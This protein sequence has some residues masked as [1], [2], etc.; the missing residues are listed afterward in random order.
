M[1][2]VGRALMSDPRLLMLDE[3]SLGLAPMVVTEIFAVLAK[4]NAFRGDGSGGGTGCKSLSG[5]RPMGLCF[6]KRTH[7]PV[8]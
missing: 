6:G 4:I 5:T 3:P 8:G 7:R 2:A 1:L